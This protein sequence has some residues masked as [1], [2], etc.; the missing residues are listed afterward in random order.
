MHVCALRTAEALKRCMLTPALSLSGDTGVSTICLDQNDV[1]E[2]QDAASA[3]ST[4][5]DDCEATGD[6]AERKGLHSLVWTGAS[7]HK[8]ALL[9]PPRFPYNDLTRIKNGEM[10]VRNQDKLP[11]EAVPV[12]ATRAG[13]CKVRQDALAGYV[14]N[15]GVLTLANCISILQA[16]ESRS[17]ACHTKNALGRD[18]RTWQA[19]TRATIAQ[20]T[21]TPT[22]THAPR[23]RA[24]HMRTARRTAG[25]FSSL[26]FPFLGRW[27][28]GASQRRNSG[29]HRGHRRWKSMRSRLAKHVLARGE[30][31]TQ[32]LQ[33]P[34][35]LCRRAE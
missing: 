6:V 14:L 24:T 35:T 20:P 29:G 34:R 15:R 12:K 32:H 25:T 30:R 16:P 13:V 27:P 3:A 31:P 28:K 18:P 5:T 1:R 17:Q 4:P 11:N 2:G 10:G 21:P 9:S 7:P 26:Y 22:T 23:L 19:Q 8:S 33:L